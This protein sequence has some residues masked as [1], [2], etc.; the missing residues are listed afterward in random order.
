MLLYWWPDEGWQRST[1]TV[2]AEVALQGC[3]VRVSHV[4]AYTRQIS[5]LRRV[6][7]TLLDARAAFYGAR[8]CFKFS[9]ANAAG[10]A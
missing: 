2:A 8:W 7:D 4:A 1:V 9:P 10:A 6:A 5:A 3:R